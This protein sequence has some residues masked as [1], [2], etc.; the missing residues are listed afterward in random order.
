MPI[1]LRR[2]L[3]TLMRPANIKAIKTK[4]K[5]CLRWPMIKYT[6]P[7]ATES[8][9]TPNEIGGYCNVTR[10]CVVEARSG[11]FL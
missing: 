11:L 2:K 10:P 6:I 1:Y 4:Y 9:Q 5:P 3:A 8:A 7:R